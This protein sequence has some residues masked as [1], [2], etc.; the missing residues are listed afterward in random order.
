MRRRR[1]VGAAVAA[2]PARA[3][4]VRSPLRRH[5]GPLRHPAEPRAVQR[6]DNCERRVRHLPAARRRQAGALRRRPRHQTRHPAAGR[7]PGAG[8]RRG[9]HLHRLPAALRDHHPLLP[10]AL[11]APRGGA[12]P[13]LPHRIPPGRS[14]RRVCRLRLRLC[15]HPGRGGAA[16]AGGRQRVH[17]QRGAAACRGA[18]AAGGGGGGCQRLG[19]HAVAHGQPCLPAPAGAR[20]PGR[21]IA[22]GATGVGHGACRSHCLHVLPVPPRQ[23]LS[24]RPGTGRWGTALPR[25]SDPTAAHLEE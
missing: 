2:Q 6:Q 7:W 21:Q 4:S 22:M 12:E 8:R 5:A 18:A 9:S 10:A 20:S 23:P 11:P 1:A 13:P 15:R 14:E 16:G 17:R 19:H 3:G 24:G 25:A